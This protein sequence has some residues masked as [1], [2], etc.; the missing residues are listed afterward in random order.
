MGLSIQ[1]K[2]LRFS[3]FLTALILTACLNPAT[4][5]SPKEGGAD[6]VSKPESLPAGMSYAAATIA[7]S[8][9]VSVPVSGAEGA[10]A[11]YAFD[12]T[13]L[14][15]APPVWINLEASTGAVS[16]SQVPANAPVGTTTYR[17]KAVGTGRYSGVP[18]KKP[19]KLLLPERGLIKGRAGFWTLFLK[20]SRRPSDQ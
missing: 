13:G 8:H 15:P 18:A 11:E 5:T 17:I 16:I 12:T 3:A 1:M 14:N 10:T 6:T 4:P 19:I 9:S 2:M 20:W 7:R